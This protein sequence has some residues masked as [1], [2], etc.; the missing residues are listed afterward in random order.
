MEPLCAA[1][2]IGSNVSSSARGQENP[3]APRRADCCPLL[4]V[5]IPSDRG[6]WCF[7]HNMGVSEFLSSKCCYATMYLPLSMTLCAIVCRRA[8]VLN[9]SY[10]HKRR[11]MAICERNMSPSLAAP[12]TILAALSIRSSAPAI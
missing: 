6:Y 4:T 9:G 2:G 12:I 1:Y 7:A 5:V 3:S 11:R 8:T 10:L